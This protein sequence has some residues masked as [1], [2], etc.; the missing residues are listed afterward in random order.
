MYVSCVFRHVYLRPNLIF[1]FS[2]SIR[3]KFTIVDRLLNCVLFCYDS[4]RNLSSIVRMSDINCVITKTEK[5]IHINYLPSFCIHK[6]QLQQRSFFLSAFSDVI[7]RTFL[8]INTRKCSNVKDG[9][10]RSDVTLFVRCLL[11][12]QMFVLEASPLN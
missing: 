12:M 11:V 10:T 8:K 5:N 3:K 2:S 9:Q 7:D 6:Q 4:I 1:R